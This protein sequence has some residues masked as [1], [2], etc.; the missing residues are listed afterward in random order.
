MVKS[1]PQCAASNRD[2]ATFCSSCGA[3]FAAPTVKPVPSVR[4]VSPAAPSTVVRVPPP[5]MCYYHPS[6]PAVYVCSRCGRPICRDDSRAYGDLILCP[7]CYA[8]IYPVAAPAPTMSYAPPPPMALP[9]P[10]PFPAPAP[11]GAMG[12]PGPPPI[13][14]PGFLPPR[15]RPVWG[16]ILALIA[17][18]ATI[19]AG[20]TAT[21]LLYSNLAIVPAWLVDY[22]MVPLGVGVLLGLV[23][24]L[25]AFLIWQGYST[26]GG[27]L[28]FIF[29]LANIYLAILIVVPTTIIYVAIAIGIVA[30]VLGLIAGLLGILSK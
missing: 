8:G 6:L 19:I 2:D 1:C 22:W 25:G 30:L 13:A 28:A 14:G 3:S 29:S 5:G 23:I 16:F 4:V 11:M 18:I 9:G 12:P 24:V 26:L 7:Q 10:S 15:P 17:G 27:I 21:A 20:A